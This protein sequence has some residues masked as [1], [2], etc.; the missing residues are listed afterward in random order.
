MFYKHNQFDD[1]TQEKFYIENKIIF[2]WVKK[3]YFKNERFIFINSWN[4]YKNGN[5]LEYDER[6]G[7]ASLN[8]FSKFIFNLSFQKSEYILNFREKYNV[9]FALKL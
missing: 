5:Y 2:N 9:Y 7:Y 1:Y 8:S 6:Y 4:D 3:N